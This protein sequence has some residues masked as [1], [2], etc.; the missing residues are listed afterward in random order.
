[1]IESIVGLAGHLG[2]VSGREVGVVGEVVEGAL[3]GAVGGA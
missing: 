1:M 2:W 3:V